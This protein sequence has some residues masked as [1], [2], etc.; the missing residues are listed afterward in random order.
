MAGSGYLLLYAPSN[1]L[2]ARARSA[3]PTLR[4]AAGLG[5]LALVLVAV[6]HRVALA[7]EDGAPGWLNLAVLVLLWDAVKVLL[8]ALC[9]LLRAFAADV[10]RVLR[11]CTNPR[12][13]WS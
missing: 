6:G 9:V 8:V 11:C 3:R 1:L 13:A 12:R 10:R 2:L 4:L 5:L 7:I